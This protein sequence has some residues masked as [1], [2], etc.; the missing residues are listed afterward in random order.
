MRPED[1]ENRS[2]CSLPAL[3]I[4]R[5]VPGVKRAL[6]FGGAKGVH[7]PFDFSTLRANG[8]D[9]DKSGELSPP[10]THPPPC[11]TSKSSR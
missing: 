7:L 1:A 2:P 6:C 4:E 8:G 10:A 11:I 5:M 9:I 3:S